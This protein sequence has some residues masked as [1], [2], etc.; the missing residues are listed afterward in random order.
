MT[1]LIHPQSLRSCAGIFCKRLQSRFPL[2]SIIFREPRK[3]RGSL[4][5]L[6][7]WC[8]QGLRA[9]VFVEAVL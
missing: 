7:L 1:Y 8:Y 4:P 2:H 6:A 9:D 3:G 5:S